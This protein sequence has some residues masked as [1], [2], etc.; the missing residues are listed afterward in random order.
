LKL[1]TFRSRK[2]N[3]TKEIRM[4]TIHKTDT[5]QHTKCGAATG[6]RSIYWDRVNCTACRALKPADAAD[7]TS[8][9]HSHRGEGVNYVD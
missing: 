1:D 8:F 4:A 5:V 9:K 6:E 2:A 3:P 7:R